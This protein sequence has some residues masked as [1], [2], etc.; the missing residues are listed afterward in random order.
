MEIRVN[1]IGHL[2][3]NGTGNDIGGAPF[4]PLPNGSIVNIV[5]D[6]VNPLTTVAQVNTTNPH[7]LVSGNFVQISGNSNSGYN[8]TWTIV[9]T[10]ASTFEINHDWDSDG[11]GGTWRKRAAAF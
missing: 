7:G 8:S 11:T 4:P 3:R 2:V 6:A 5:L 9:V 10:G 1:R